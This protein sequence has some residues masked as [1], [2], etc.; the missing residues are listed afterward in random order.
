MHFRE[1]WLT[2][3]GIWGEPEL[4]FNDLGSKGKILSVS[5]GIFFHGFGEINALFSGI[6]EA[7]TP[8]G[9]LPWIC[10][11]SLGPQHERC[12]CRTLSPNRL[13]TLAGKVSHYLSFLL[14]GREVLAWGRS[15]T[16]ASSSDVLSR[17]DWYINRCCLRPHPL[18]RFLSKHIKY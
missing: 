14:S 15:V 5:W 6:K 2:F 12:F 17:D 3:L 10:D 13:K 18:L 16:C 4:I 7:Q 1:N 9:P 8:W 11:S